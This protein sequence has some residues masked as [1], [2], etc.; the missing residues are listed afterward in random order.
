MVVDDDESIRNLLQRSL[1]KIGHS[2]IGTG[3]GK[4]AISLFRNNT[5]DCL[6]LDIGLPD[7]DG[8]KVLKI[9]KTMDPDISVVM[10]TGVEDIDIVRRAMRLGAFDYIIKPIEIEEIRSILK[11]VE[12]RNSFIK[13]KKD[14]QKFL[15]SKIREESQKIKNLYLKAITSLIK[16]LEA[17]DA[18][19]KDHSENVAKLAK[20]IGGKLGLDNKKIQAL[21]IAALL[22]DIGKIGVPDNI[23]L[24]PAKLT[25]EE[26]EKVKKHPVTGV[27]ILK[28]IIDDEDIINAILHHHER[29]DGKGFP[30]GLK[31][32][33]IP[34]FARIIAIADSIEAMSS[35]RPYRS[36]MTH[37]KIIQELKENSG[38][39]FDPKIVEVVLKMLEE[40]NG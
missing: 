10:I 40:K 26:Y 33:N 14:Y 11:K 30:N 17:K 2:S 20:K 13:M 32:E 5:F 16:T 21:S 28:P 15:E 1:D 4:E 19:H 12:D 23:L 39:Q 31:G 35:K 29:Y 27:E 37:Q 36:T 34:L 9:L 24:K 7:I 8:I 6:L 38:K 18:Y 3:Y 22:H 25:A